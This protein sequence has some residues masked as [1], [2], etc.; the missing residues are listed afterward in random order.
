MSR[1]S[2]PGQVE[3]EKQ[4]NWPVRQQVDTEQCRPT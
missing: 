4:F 2:R 1:A 3:R